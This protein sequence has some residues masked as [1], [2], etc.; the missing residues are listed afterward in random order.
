MDP[1]G[2]LCLAAAED[3][4]QENRQVNDHHSLHKNHTRTETRERVDVQKRTST[5]ILVALY[6][7]QC[8]NEGVEPLENHIDILSDIPHQLIVHTRECQIRKRVTGGAVVK[9]S[10]G[11]SLQVAALLTTLAPPKD[12]T[13]LPVLDTLD[14]SSIKLSEEN[15]VKMV[16]NALLWGPWWRLRCLILRDCGI[17]LSHLR[18]LACADAV[19]CFWNLEYFDISHNPGIGRTQTGIT[20]GPE[21]FAG[22]ELAF[23]VHFWKQTRLRWLSVEHCHLGHKA[24]RCILTILRK[25]EI[26]KSPLE[27][28]FAIHNGTR[29][30]LEN[31]I[32]GDDAT[33]IDEDKADMALLF[34]ELTLIVRELPRLSFLKINGILESDLSAIVRSWESVHDSQKR[35]EVGEDNTLQLATSDEPA[36]C[37]PSE[38]VFPNS[39]FDM[40]AE[41]LEERASPQLPKQILDDF[42]LN[43]AIQKPAAANDN[44][45][46]TLVA[47]NQLDK[48]SLN[49]ISPAK[50]SSKALSRN[51]GPRR[52]ATQ[53]ARSRNQNQLYMGGD[54]HD[55]LPLVEIDIESGSEDNPSNQRSRG[56]SDGESSAYDSPCSDDSARAHADQ[57]PT[58][59]S[60]AAHGT[61]HQFRLRDGTLDEDSKLGRVYR[62][63]ARKN[64]LR[65]PNKTHQKAA[66]R[67]FKLWDQ[68]TENSWDRR[69]WDN[70]SKTQNDEPHILGQLN[71]LFDILDRYK[72]GI[73]FP[74]PLWKKGHGEHAFEAPK[75][76]SESPK[77]DPRREKKVLKTSSIPESIPERTDSHE[78][79]MEG[80]GRPGKS[81]AFVLSSE[82]EEEGVPSEIDESCSEEEMSQAA[83]EHSKKIR[84]LN[85][86]SAWAWDSRVE[87]HPPNKEVYGPT[88]GKRQRKQLHGN[89]A[90]LLESQMDEF[91]ASID[92]VEPA[93]DEKKVPDWSSDDDIPLF[94]GKDTKA[95]MECI[96][97]DSQGESLDS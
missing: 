37:L 35:V 83:R 12:A 53:K 13:I 10:G 43:K 1:L 21:A 96:I 45:P 18:V 71:L 88:R 78:E 76:D 26:P 68:C 61:H 92:Q 20:R 33:M 95:P 40:D 24:L 28:G 64:I 91:D 67:A 86:L 34:E 2:D 39:S 6:K 49:I 97:P 4:E 77:S 75:Y 48:Y 84:E 93:I 73:G 79:S 17:E 52:S 47:T 32:L 90:S 54:P 87:S 72:L 62:S 69:R 51:R 14:L 70:P 31:L 23:L 5:E 55:A 81:R 7:E 3:A 9:V 56:E 41:E 89:V 25:Y 38:H 80:G 57:S 19:P 16:E 94:V 63:D 30:V 50:M 15:L 29:P 46:M 82:E 60:P 44:E 27:C 42:G 8:I 58:D 66:K 85:R 74:F 11:C 22:T 59:Q 65:I 36:V